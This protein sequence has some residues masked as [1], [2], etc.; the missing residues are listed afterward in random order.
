MTLE[1][2]KAT[3]EAQ[4]R[5]V[6]DDWTQAVQAKDINRL[7]SHYTP[8]VLSFDLAPPLQ[9]H[10]GELRSGMEEWFE[11]FRG[12]IGYEI[13]DLSITVGDDVAFSHSLNR[14]S[15]ARTSGEQ[16]DVWV[17]STVCFRKIDGKWMVTHEHASVPFYM[18]GSDR[19]AVDLKP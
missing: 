13:R 12:P 15:G 6:T 8:D 14:I 2:R 18:D 16:T 7:F 10:R 9:H 1:N 5:R 3:D 19:A 4:I 11:T 17:R